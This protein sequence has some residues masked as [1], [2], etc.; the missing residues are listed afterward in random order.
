[1]S[2]YRKVKKFLDEWGIWSSESSMSSVNWDLTIS[3]SPF[4]KDSW[5]N[6][7]L[8]GGVPTHLKNMKANWDDFFPIYG[9]I[10]NV[11]NHQP[12]ILL[13]RAEMKAVAEIDHPRR[14]S[15]NVDHE[16]AFKAFSLSGSGRLYKPFLQ[17]KTILELW[18]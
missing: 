16:T 1:M 10:K 18:P 14:V 9:K 8:V 15:T 3:I 7:N 6:N 2:N 4:Q 17:G 12:A 5:K 13:A 11:P